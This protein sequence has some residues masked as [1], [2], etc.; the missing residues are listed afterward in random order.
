MKINSTTIRTPT[1]F[2]PETFKLSKSGR[3]AN[4]DMT[5]ETIA[6][7]KKFTL[8]YN[9]ITGAELK[10]I[11]D[12]LMSTTNFFTFEYPDESTT[13]TATVYVGAIPR[14]LWTLTGGRRYSGVEFSLIEK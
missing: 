5:F 8:S 7:K 9:D 10:A 3:V 2:K 6:I 13:A 1:T 12:I 14:E 11:L 4:G